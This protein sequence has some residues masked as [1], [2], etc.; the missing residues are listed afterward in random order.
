MR[1][2]LIIKKEAGTELLTLHLEAAGYNVSVISDMS[3]TSHFADCGKN[4]LVVIEADA[5]DMDEISLV[6]EIRK[7]SD[8]IIILLIRGGEVRDRILGMSLGADECISIPVDAMEFVAK[9]N[10]LINLGCRMN[11]SGAKH[12]VIRY[13]D[14][15]LDTSAMRLFKNESPVLLTPKEYRLLLN[16]MNEPGRVF[17]KV[18]LCSMLFDEP[19]RSDANAL[20]VHISHLREKI[21]DEPKRPMY[22]FNIR[23]IGYRFGKETENE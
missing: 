17:T 9:V 21:E 12:S 5:D 2:I 4:D 6:K 22:I 10:A 13:R 20:M 8:V 14:L 16:M 3:D 7:K 18:E 11:N 23:G 1:K 15:A 19:I